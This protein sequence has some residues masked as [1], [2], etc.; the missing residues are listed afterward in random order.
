MNIIRKYIPSSIVL[1]AVG[2][3]A[4]LVWWI[5]I[6]SRSLIDTRENFYF[7][8]A[9]GL[10]TIICGITGLTKSKRWGSFSSYI[11]RFII[12]LSSGF[13]AWGIGTLIIGYFNIALDQIYPYPSLADFAYILSWPLWIIAMFNLSKATGARARFKSFAGKLITLVVIVFAFAI[14]YYLLFTVARGGMFEISSDS[15]L[16]LFFDFAYPVG[17]IFIVASS[18]LLFGLS[19]NYLGGRFKFPIFL[20]IFGFIL[21]YAA[22]IVFTYINTVGIYHVGNWVDMLYVT[23][24]L[25]LGI[26][27]NLFDQKILVLE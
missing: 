14:S 26:G 6:F 13:I 11:G 12:F 19:F 9:L 20:I 4:L 17:D 21:N 16:R 24:F 3:L 23:V 18:L 10:F 22:D 1:L 8:I 5:T 2:Y 7:G 27:V 25:V 15:Y